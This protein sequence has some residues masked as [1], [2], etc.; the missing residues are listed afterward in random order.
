ML[1]VLKYGTYLK[2]DTPFQS[3]RVHPD[4]I[5]RCVLLHHYLYAQCTLDHCLSFCSL[6]FLV[7]YCLSFDLRLLITQLAS[8]NLSYPHDNHPIYIVHVRHPLAVNILKHYPES[9]LFYNGGK[10]KEEIN[11][12]ERLPDDEDALLTPSYISYLITSVPHTTNL[13]IQR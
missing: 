13:R 7:L 1:Y 5:V 9:D 2:N 4:F 11:N 3:T 6:F 12:I 10:F 8:S